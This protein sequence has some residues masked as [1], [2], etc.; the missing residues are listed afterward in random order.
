MTID[1]HKRTLAIIH[2]S[3]GIFKLFVYG[4]LIVFFSSFLPFIESE[5]IKEEGQEASLIFD[6]ITS[7]FYSILVIA[8]TLTSIPSIIG[9]FAVLKEKEYGLVLIL[10]SGCIS[11]LSFPIGTAVGVYSIWVFVENN[12]QKK[13]AELDG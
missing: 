11:L 3:L 6:F 4:G 8:A 7:A 13:N 10:I 1:S 2:I 5:I 12:R 9:G